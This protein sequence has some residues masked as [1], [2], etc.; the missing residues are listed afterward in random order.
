LKAARFYATSIHSN[1]ESSAMKKRFILAA[2]PLLLPAAARAADDYVMLKINGQNISAAE[3]QKSWE[4]LFP[5]GTAPAFDTASDTVRQNVLRGIVSEKLLLTEAEKQGVETLDAVRQEVEAARRKI[6][7][8]Y[9]LE[10]KSANLMQE[11]DI[12]AAY[13]R[14]VT[15]LAKEE[16]IRARHILVASE[17][18][19]EELY[20]RIEKGESFAKLAEEYSKDPASAAEGGDLGYFT[21]DKMVK[22][23]AEAAF[24][25]KK[26]EVSEPVKS[27][28]G[29]HL[30]TL[31]DRRSAT[32]PTLNEAREAI[33]M[34]LQ[35]EKLSSYINSLLSAA[36]ITYYSPKGKEIPFN[37]KP[38]P[39]TNDGE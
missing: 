1:D 22:P 34:Q 17:K 25:L 12:Q 31:E 9:F 7:L 8:R 11:D 39:L 19:A 32:V 21:A 13:G 29:W 15:S 36:E 6:V 37:K 16:E 3:V 14:L 27:P 5:P 23:F 28:F 10:Q 35:D 38:V 2:L 20:E 4:S 24:T 30:I 33:V 26:G 18:E